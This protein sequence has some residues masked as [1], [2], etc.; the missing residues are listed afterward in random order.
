MTIYLA[1]PAFPKN[2]PGSR[3]EQDDVAV[4]V[5]QPTRGRAGH[6]WSPYLA[7]LQVGFG[8]RCVTADDRTLLPSDFT[9]VFPLLE[10]RYVS[11]PL[12]VPHGGGTAAAGAWALPSTLPGGART[13]LPGTP[14]MR[15][16]AAVTRPIPALRPHSS[17]RNLEGQAD[18]SRGERNI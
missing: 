16:T 3:D 15:D 17:I 18:L 6:P 13:F 8:R 9:L 4:G 2:P 14:T 7:L 11:V 5:K 1:R 10:G 12:S